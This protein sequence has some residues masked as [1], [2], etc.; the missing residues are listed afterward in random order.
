MELVHRG[1]VPR[2]MGASPPGHG[3]VSAPYLGTRSLGDMQKVLLS[4]SV[5][6]GPDSGHV[7]CGACR[8]CLCHDPGTAGSSLVGSA[9][10]PRTFWVCGCMSPLKSPWGHTSTGTGEGGTAAC[11]EE[12]KAQG[13]VWVLC[14]P[15]PRSEFSPWLRQEGQRG[16]GKLQ[17]HNTLIGK[18]TGSFLS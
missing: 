4:H 11:C 17:L 8:L 14:V 7:P 6:P 3:A 9:A 12:A 5:A 16:N 18:I 10:P 13:P 15:G 1:W 2:G